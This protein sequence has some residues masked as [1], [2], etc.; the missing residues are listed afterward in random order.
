MEHGHSGTIGAVSSE[1]GKG[2][3]N[4]LWIAAPDGSSATDVW[5]TWPASTDHLCAD[6]DNHSGADPSDHGLIW[7]RLNYQGTKIAWAEMYRAGTGV[8]NQAL[9][10]WC[11]HVADVTWTG[12]TP[13]LSAI[14]TFR[15]ADD[16]GNFYE[17]Y[18][19]SPDGSKL[20]FASSDGTDGVGDTQIWQL[21]IQAGGALGSPAR[22]SVPY[23]EGTWWDYNEFAFYTPDGN[24]IIFGRTRDSHIN[25]LLHVAGGLDYWIVDADGT[26][27]DRLTNYNE[28]WSP[29]FNGYTNVG[30]WA[31][32][33]NNP[34][35]L[36]VGRCDNTLCS[37]GDIASV[38]L[39]TDASGSGTGLTGKYYDGTD[40]NTGTLVTTEVNK[41]V[42]FEFGNTP[43]ASGVPTT[44]YSVRWTG[45]VT[46]P[47]TGSYTLCTYTDDG[48]RLT[49]AGVQI[50][51]DWVN[52]A[53]RLDCAAPRNL[54]AGTSYS[55]K[56]DMYNASGGG[57]AKLIWS[58]PGHGT[59][60]IPN[61]R[62]SPN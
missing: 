30:G 33:P 20:L 48:S 12:G 32:D 28:P 13:S 27:L 8:T 1:P 35:H 10:S 23:R 18:G 47:V 5:S 2:T 3:Y 52:H 59:E 6:K 41:Q 43:P 45:H 53:A 46:A 25:G 21:P 56:M 9:G 40:P 61:G 7:P 54:T 14:K 55:I 29:E 26:H 16:T 58:V 15:F 60:I 4:D 37:T 22:L 19:F 24:H 49:F 39:T 38:T 57:T 34:N 51:N 50:V 44:N 62:L 36:L 11:L 17:T 42:D 31:F